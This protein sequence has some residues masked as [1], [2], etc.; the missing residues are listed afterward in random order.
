[1]SAYCSFHCCVS[2]KSEHCLDYSIS[3]LKTAVFIFFGDNEQE[4]W[5]QG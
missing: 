2:K 5:K 1:M 4:A 3:V